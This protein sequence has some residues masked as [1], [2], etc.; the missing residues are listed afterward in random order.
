MSEKT[1]SN[2]WHSLVAMLG[3]TLGLMFALKTVQA[4]TVSAASVTMEVGGHGTKSTWVKPGGGTFKEGGTPTLH[5]NSASG[6]VVFCIEPGQDVVADGEGYTGT[7]Y[8]T[9][10]DSSTAKQVISAIAYYGYQKQKSVNNYI[11]TQWMI[12]EELGYKLQS[13]QAGPVSKAAYQTFKNTVNS[14]VATFTGNPSFH[15]TTVTVKAGQS[16]TVT[17]TTG[18]FANYAA[19][20]SSNTTG[21]TVKKSGNSLTITASA[22]SKDSGAIQFVPQIDANYQGTPLIASH[23]T[24]QDVIQPRVDSAAHRTWINVKVEKNV[25]VVL[26]KYDVSTDFGKN[27]PLAGVT[28]HFTK[29]GKDYGDFTTDA[30]GQ[31]DL[32][33]N[34]SEMT[35]D[36]TYQETKTVDG[37]KLDSTVKKFSISAT[38]AG[39]TI[40]LTATNERVP[41]EVHTTATSED[42]THIQEPHKQ[43]TITD[44]V[45]YANAVPGKEYTVVGKLMDKATGEALLD[46]NGKAVT[47]TMTFVAKTATGYVDMPFTFDAALLAGKTAVAFES[48]SRD[49]REVAVHNDINDVPQTITF[50]TPKIGTTATDVDGSHDVLPDGDLVINDVVAY[51]DLIVGKT[52]NIKGQL[53]DKATGKVVLDAKGNPITPEKTFVADKAD[54]S[55]TMTYTVDAS[56]AMGKEFVVFENLYRDNNL[57]VS[58]ADVNDEG[59]TVKVVTPVVHTT[60]TSDEGDK[61]VMPEVDVTIKDA[62]AYS[63][64]VVGKHYSVTGYLHY[65]DGSFVLD[66]K[67]EKISKTVSFTAEKT[68]GTIDVTF[69][70]DG[71]LLA[72]KDVV[73]FENLYHNNN[74]I[75]F[76]EDVNDKDQTVTFPEIELHTTATDFEGSKE[77]VPEEKVTVKDAVAYHDLIV[78]KTY[79][80]TGYLHYTDGSFVKNA[81]GSKVSKTVTFKAEKADGTIDVEFVVDGRALAGKDVVAFEYLYHNGKLIASHEDIN[82]KDQTVHFPKIEL[83]TT[84]NSDGKKTVTASQNMTINDFVEFHDLVI[85]KTYTVKG[86]LMDKATGKPVLIN[87]KKVTAEKTFKA[88]AKDM[89]VTMTFTLDSS[90]L[91]GHDVVAFEDL[92]HDGNLIASHADIND[93]GQT[94]HIAS[95]PKLT[96]TDDSLNGTLLALGVVALISA[97]GIAFY[98]LRKRA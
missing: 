38:D 87:G 91:G 49:G 78:G 48:L 51:H 63:D 62:V 18:R 3:L 17:D 14:K 74:L 6:P 71:R 5:L 94:V 37:F 42:G 28:F 73:V 54:G 58:H 21:T 88:T 84:A 57:V 1:K 64:L 31:I 85:G 80:M 86:Y 29:D 68:E 60:A 61:Q 4:N 16:V 83:H 41:E 52:Y 26:Q 92:Y 89:K 90:S 55:V 15:N 11:M 46:D 47:K 9:Y 56:K 19:A 53:M 8:K 76:H 23:A 95:A 81:D 66:A 36:W 79:T 72:G 34:I 33:K 10:Q 40:T 24:R 97:A 39:K 20:P 98:L 75:A 70:V 2:L 27:D 96:Q 43:V 77:V 59:Q 67:G 12:W 32:N 69:T 44:R 93:A 25:N 65:T 82:D 7:G 50:S 22:S 13:V 30:E 35:G 45:F